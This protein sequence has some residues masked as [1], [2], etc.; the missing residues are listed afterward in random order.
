M[1]SDRPYR[2]ALDKELIVNM[3]RS[4]TRKGW[5]QAEMT[6]IFFELISSNCF[7]QTDMQIETDWLQADH[8]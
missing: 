2:Q 4:E 6:D 3:L 5:W 8:F 1:S 7:E